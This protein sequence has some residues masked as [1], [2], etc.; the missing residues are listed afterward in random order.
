MDSS[1]SIPRDYTPC[2][3]VAADMLIVNAM[4]T[5]SPT[6]YKAPH[7]ATAASAFRVV[8][9]NRA[10]LASNGVDRL[11]RFTTRVKMAKLPNGDYRRPLSISSLA[12]CDGPGIFP[13]GLEACC[14]TLV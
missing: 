7:V 3:V 1:R 13:F 5:L 2:A 4:G 8:L 10:I 14:A 11:T 6:N 9:R 12:R